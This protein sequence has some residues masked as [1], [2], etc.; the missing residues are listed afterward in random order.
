M[1]NLTLIKLGWQKLGFDEISYS[2]KLDNERFSKIVFLI[3]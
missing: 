3:Q 2:T 1:L